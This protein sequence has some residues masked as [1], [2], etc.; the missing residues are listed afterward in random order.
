MAQG[1][2][3]L[4]QSC[5]S[6]L[7]GGVVQTGHQQYATPS[8]HTVRGR[9]GTS[10]LQGCAGAKCQWLFLRRDPKS[11]RCALY[12]IIPDPDPQYS[13]TSSLGAMGWIL[14]LR[15][16]VERPR[17]PG[18]RLPNSVRAPVP[19]EETS[20][21]PATQWAVLGPG[22]SCCPSPS[23]PGWD[24]WPGSVCSRLARLRS[25]LG[26]ARN[27]LPEAVGRSL[28]S[29]GEAQRWEAPSHCPTGDEHADGAEAAGTREAE[30]PPLRAAARMQEGVG[31]TGARE[32]GS[33]R[34]EAVGRGRED[35]PPARP[36]DV[37]DVTTA[38]REEPRRIAWSRRP[39][40][41]PY[42]PECTGS[43]G[44]LG[45]PMRSVP[46]SFA[47]AGTQGL[48]NRGNPGSP[49]PSWGMVGP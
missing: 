8:P 15:V 19:S 18:M 35:A 1:R 3:G 9:P 47:S 20:I 29:L 10:R 46:A 31:P 23:L 41:L 39:D 49:T 26:L 16:Q 17:P 37:G 42:W 30:A 38:P 28:P 4:L 24:L 34:T 27:P 14:W 45:R 2:T 22:P 44:L 11:R 36:R 7:L 5:L 40:A 25:P 48:T 32:G 21:L 33:H 6:F 13:F 12:P 43:A